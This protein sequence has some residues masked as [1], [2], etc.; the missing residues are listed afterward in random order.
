MRYL[1]EELQNHEYKEVTHRTISSYPS[2]NQTIKLLTW[3]RVIAREND[4]EYLA[5]NL[6]ENN[7]ELGHLCEKLNNLNTF[8][9][10]LESHIHENKTISK[11]SRKACEIPRTIGSLLEYNS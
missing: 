8:D 2:I 11:L 6:F 9:V 4:K 10:F 7:V 1:D 3:K 5:Y